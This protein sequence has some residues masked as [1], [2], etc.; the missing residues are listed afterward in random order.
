[1][2]DTAIM[3]HIR[4]ISFKSIELNVI[5]Q[6]TNCHNKIMRQQQKSNEPYIYILDIIDRHA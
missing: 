2:R 1:M 3:E 6:L 5:H 4:S